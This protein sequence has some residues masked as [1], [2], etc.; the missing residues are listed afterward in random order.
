M[1]PPRAARITAIIL[2]IIFGLVYVF[3][4]NCIF[5]KNIRPQVNT[6]SD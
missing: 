6:L 1:R 4:Y 3:G 5:D 2:A